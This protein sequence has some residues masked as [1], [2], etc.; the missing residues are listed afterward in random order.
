MSTEEEDKDP[1]KKEVDNWFDYFVPNFAAAVAEGHFPVK[2][3]GLWEVGPWVKSH[4]EGENALRLWLSSPNGDEHSRRYAAEWLR[5]EEARRA[6]E[7]RAR[8]IE[9][10]AS[11]AKAAKESARWTMVAAIFAG[12]GTFVTAGTS[13]Y[14][15]FNPPLVPASP[16]T[17]VFL[18]PTPPA[19][20]QAQTSRP[21]ESNAAPSTSRLKPKVP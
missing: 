5:R 9:V 7:W 2:F 19:T 13:L 8:E 6:D 3:T 16:P 17:Q 21:R 12:V 11:S 1:Y 20:I 4:A 18:L 10:A 15:I 14:G